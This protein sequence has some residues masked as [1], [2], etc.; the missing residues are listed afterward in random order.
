M[1]ELSGLNQ[2]GAKPS[3]VCWWQL[4][5][6]LFPSLC[7]C[8]FASSGLFLAAFI[9]Q[10]QVES[11]SLW[12]CRPMPWARRRSPNSPCASLP[13]QAILVLLILCWGYLMESSLEFV[14]EKKEL[15][16]QCTINLIVHIWNIDLAHSLSCIDLPQYPDDSLSL[17]ILCNITSLNVVKPLCL[18]LSPSGVISFCI[19]RKAKW[20]KW[21][22]CICY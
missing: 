13:R 2:R 14:S 1:W 18:L 8:D 16:T 20:N 3:P 22:S 12:I 7:L 4:L 10:K 17:Q 21:V 9:L 19:C 15:D 6:F 5:L 11:F